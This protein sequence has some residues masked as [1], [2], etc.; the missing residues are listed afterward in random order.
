MTKIKVLVV[1]D[2][3]VV[4]HGLSM[5]LDQEPDMETV[6]EAR[7]GVEALEKIRSLRPDVVLLDLV[8][9]EMDGIEVIRRVMTERL[10]SRIL[11]LT[12]FAT[13]DRIFPAVKAGAMGYLLKDADP[14][15]LANAVRQVH[16]GRV[17]LSPLVAAKL[18]AQ[19]QEPPEG[20]L[21]TE[22]LTAREV[23]V[24]RLVARG[25]SNED[26]AKELVISETTARTHVSN[27]LGK[28][29]LASRTQAALYALR[30]GI[31]FLHDDK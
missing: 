30:E 12:S 17:S 28:L 22:P 10:R 27:I 3:V 24:I 9:P 11:V 8:M 31:A 7:N 26:I 1:D 13:E 25:L 29:H 14:V 6:G 21:T 20:Q 16:N 2:H 15:E 4:S 5:L 19:I 23:E 18:M